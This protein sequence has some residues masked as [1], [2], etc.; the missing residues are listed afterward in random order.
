MAPMA[1]D[2]IVTVV[3]LDDETTAH[4]RLLMRQA[5]A[6]LSRQWHWGN[7]AEADLVVVDPETLAGKVSRTRCES[8]GVRCAI[9]CAPDR[10]LPAALLLLTPLRLANVIDVLR[11]A[12]EPT[13]QADA[14]QHQDAGFYPDGSAIDGIEPGGAHTTPRPEL[15]GQV[16]KGLEEHMRDEPGL[17]LLP[18]PMVRVLDAA[19]HGATSAQSSRREQRSKDA[20]DAIARSLPRNLSHPAMPGAARQPGLEPPPG[21]P[22]GIPAAVPPALGGQRLLAAYLGGELLGGPAQIRLEGMPS[23]TLDPKHRVFHSEAPLSHLARY[24]TDNLPRS[25]WRAV[26][27]GELAQLRVSQPPR[28]YEY[29]VWLEALL[30]SSGRLAS[31]LD[32]GGSYR[33]RQ[34]VVVDHQ[35]HAHGAITHAMRTPTKLNEIASRSSA[36]MEAVF[37]VVNAYAAIGWL[38]STPRERLKQAVPDKPAGL[39]ARLKRPFQ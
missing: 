9:V 15:S 18:Q 37:D 5:A 19:T 35:Y 27:S 39:W 3:G 25:G 20:P 1:R 30:R 8:S 14:V 38:E 26:T 13:V 17:E 34:M 28:L 36:G 31:H 23:L 12:A 2:L 7:E 11:R 32:P 16:A 4:L 22:L 21:L 24:C 29:L 10:A 6:K 33:L